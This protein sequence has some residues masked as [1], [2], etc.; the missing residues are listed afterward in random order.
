M[1]QNVVTVVWWERKPGDNP[2][3]KFVIFSVLGVM[4]GLIMMVFLTALRNVGAMALFTVIFAGILTVPAVVA[5]RSFMRGLTTRINDTITEV[6]GG[7]GVGLS[8][9]QLRHLATSGEA[10][11]LLVCGMPGLRLHVQRVLAVPDDAPE[12]WQAVITAVPPR[13]GL[14]SF[15]RLLDA[16]LKVR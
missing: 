14:A 16:T 8:A 4:V 1:M 3:I 6:T 7:A 2:A 13:A 11:P 15:D 9:K 12:K 10:L 5:R